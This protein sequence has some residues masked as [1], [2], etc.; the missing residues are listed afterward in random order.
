MTA[1]GEGGVA[2]AYLVGSMW[3]YAAYV[4]RPAQALK[5]AGLSPTRTAGDLPRE[6]PRP[7]LGP[8]FSPR[9]R[10]PVFL[11]KK[12]SHDDL[13]EEFDRMSEVYAE[14]VQPFS[15]P[16]FD[17]AL[18]VM[19]DYLPS[20]ARVLDAGCGPGRELVRVARLVPQGEVVGVDLAAGMVK[21]AHRAARAAGLDN[22]AFFQADVGE[23]PEA[24]TAKFDLIYNCLA[25]H[26]YPEPTA[27]AASVLRCLRPGG[28]YCVVD[29]G[30]A[31]YNALSAP[32]AKWADPGWIGFH[33]PEEFRNLFREAGFCR[34]AWFELLP[35]FG[36]AVGQRS[37]GAA[38]ARI[39][40]DRGAKV[41]ARAGTQP[42][43]RA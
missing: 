7:G 19:R 30:P 3:W 39:K 37:A 1:P 20:D 10:E 28:V 15:Q 36:L 18:A 9:H 11:S 34:S 26:H 4:L 5:R 23:L 16:I 35:G 13:V 17:E 40:A 31:W 12:T 33:T 38:G 25:H 8:Y 29:P 27:A 2:G 24:F 21:T 41:R 42:G 43:G 32:I 6:P 22:C 14:F